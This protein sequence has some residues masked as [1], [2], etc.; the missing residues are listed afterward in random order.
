MASTSSLGSVH[1]ASALGLS[2]DR[3]KTCL[4]RAAVAT[5]MRTDLGENITP[6]RLLMNRLIREGSL[7]TLVRM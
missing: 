5:N 2:H 7:Y 4:G 6:G 3:A 1:P